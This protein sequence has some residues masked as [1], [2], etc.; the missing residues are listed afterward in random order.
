VPGNEK[1][2]KSESH[3]VT[4]FALHDLVSYYNIFVFY[5]KIAKAHKYE[6]KNRKQ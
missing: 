5:T 6:S 4:S 1:V 3:E 2:C